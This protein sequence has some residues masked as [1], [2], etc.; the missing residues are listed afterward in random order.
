[1]GKVDTVKGGQDMVDKTGAA[2]LAV[3]QEIEADLLLSSH[4]ETRGI[5][6]G[7]FLSSSV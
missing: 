1:V 6:L 2:L 3:G 4:V 7:F 5:V